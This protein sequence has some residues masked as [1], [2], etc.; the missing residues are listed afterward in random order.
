MNCVEYQRLISKF[1][2][3]ELKAKASA[4]LFEHLGKCAQCREF[5]ET[6]LKLNTELEK[7]QLL[8]ELSETPNNAGSQAKPVVKSIPARYV[9]AFVRYRISVPAPVAMVVTLALLALVFLVNVP[10]ERKQIAA[11]REAPPVQI[12]TLPVVKLP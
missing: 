9:S 10:L 11:V 12:T 8:T 2:D 1:V 3:F 6:L 7:A 4:E 5:F